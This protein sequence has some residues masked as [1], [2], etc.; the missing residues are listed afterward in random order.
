MARCPA[1]SAKRLRP[2]VNGLGLYVLSGALLVLSLGFFPSLSSATDLELI[3]GPGGSLFRA[4]CPQG[5]YLVG[6]AGRTGEWVDRIAPTCAP[7]LRGSQAFGLPT[8]GP[9]FGA[10]G[11]GQD[12]QRTCWGTGNK[13]LAIQSWYVETVRSPN[14][15]VQYVEIHCASLGP[16]QS[17]GLFDFGNPTA[18]SEERVTKGPYPHGCPPGEI[19]SG[20]RVRA[21]LFIDSLGLICAP[22]PARLGAPAGKLATPLVQTPPPSVPFNPQAKKLQ[23]PD[24]LFVITKPVPGERVTQGQ[25]FIAAI[26]P[27]VGVTNVAELELR[28]LDAPPGQKDSYPF[29]SIMAVNTTKL[30]QGYLVAPIVTDAYSGRWQ[31]RARAA[32]KTPPGPWSSPVP[33]QLTPGAPNKSLTPALQQ[34]PLSGSSVMQAPPA[35]AGGAASSTRPPTTSSQGGASSLFV[36]PR[37][38]EGTSKK[39]GNAPAP[40][41]QRE[42]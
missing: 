3:G 2:D 41:S 39:E 20:F 24:D 31:V 30:T 8:V 10:S 13:T 25:L 4:E 11:G 12:R 27:A 35:T 21:G 15:P 14:P 40:Q 37:G 16:A 23:V 19:A 18:A 33:F 38:V 28:Y 32:M 26:P 22:I 36:R 6:L 34:T 42:K 9:S 17:I 1:R 29:V 7:W 5:S